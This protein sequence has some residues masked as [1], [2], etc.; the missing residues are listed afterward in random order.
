LSIIKLDN[1]TKLYGKRKILDNF[2][3]EVNEG[4]FVAITGKSGSGKSTILNIIGLLETIDDGNIIIDG[5]KN[6]SPSSSESV[7]LLRST[8]SYL[9]QNFALIDEQ[10]VA[11]NLLLALRYVKESKKVKLQK[12]KEQLITVGLEGYENKKIF[13]L[14]GGEQQRVSIARI[15]L[16]PSKIV[17]ADEPTGSLDTGN[18]DTIMNLLKKLNNEG[19][20]IIIVTHDKDVAEVCGRVIQL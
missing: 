13:E 20:T 7:R 6:L 10:T 4:E 1:V 3:I 11:N 19:K 2:S 5:K 9:F 18:R 12:I 8:I 16:K 17:L 14:S 15:M